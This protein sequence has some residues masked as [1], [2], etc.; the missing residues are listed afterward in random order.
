MN[1]VVSKV[2]GQDAF[3]KL[4]LLSISLFIISVIVINVLNYYNKI[5]TPKF[6]LS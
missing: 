3:V 6:A 5:E 2:K 4:L 1:S